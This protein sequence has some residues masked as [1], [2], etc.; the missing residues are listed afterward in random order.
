MSVMEARRQ[1]H[2]LLI[3]IALRF[4]CLTGGWASSILANHSRVILDCASD[5]SSP[6][7]H[8][9]LL[10]APVLNSIAVVFSNVR[11]RT[12][13]FAGYSALSSRFNIDV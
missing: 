6:L 8:D 3:W 9:P 12:I 10:V 13:P 4:T 7:R 2:E 1:C 11:G 5:R